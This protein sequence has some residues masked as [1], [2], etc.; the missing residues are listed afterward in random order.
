MVT[1]HAILDQLCCVDK[2]HTCQTHKY[3]TCQ[4]SYTQYLSYIQISTSALDTKSNINSC[5]IDTY[6]NSCHVDAHID[7]WH[8]YTYINMSYRHIYHLYK[9]HTCN[10]DYLPLNHLINH[11]LI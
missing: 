6:N 10:A 9:Y 11:N 1:L 8:T 7:M 2:S 4:L 5:R 3:H